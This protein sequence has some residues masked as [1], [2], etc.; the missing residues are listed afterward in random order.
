MSE[1]FVGSEP[2]QLAAVCLVDCKM[3]MIVRQDNIS[4]RALADEP[5]PEADGLEDAESK[6]EGREHDAFKACGHHWLFRLPF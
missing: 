2:Y 3:R 4:R 5:V 1:L 6:T